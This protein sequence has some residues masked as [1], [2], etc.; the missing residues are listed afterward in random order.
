MH[1]F[2]LRQINIYQVLTISRHFFALT[3]SNVH[4]LVKATP[5]LI[6]TSKKATQVPQQLT[7]R[8]RTSGP[9]SAANCNAGRHPFVLY[10]LRAPLITA[11]LHN[12]DKKGEN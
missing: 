8:T 9:Q 2:I 7:H 4:I 10:G 12:K 5:G 1:S 6:H 11:F 3:L